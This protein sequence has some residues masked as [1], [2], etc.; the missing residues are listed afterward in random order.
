MIDEISQKAMTSLIKGM[1]K[2]T[3]ALL[4]LMHFI[5]KQL[6]PEFIYTNKTD[7]KSQFKHME[8]VVTKI[9]SERKL[10]SRYNVTKSSYQKFS[11]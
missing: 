8:T 3:D 2:Q 10:N 7:L 4:M 11:R 9:H 5:K 6:N 1:C